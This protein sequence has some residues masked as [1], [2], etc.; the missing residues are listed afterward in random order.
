[1]RI[2]LRLFAT[3]VILGSSLALSACGGGSSGSSGNASTPSVTRSIL[4]ISPT[5]ALTA[6]GAATADIRLNLRDQNGNPVTN[7]SATITLQADFGNLQYTNTNGHVTGTLTSTQSGDDTVSF[8]ID[9]SKSPNTGRVRFVAGPPDASKS[10]ITLRVPGSST[11]GAPQG[12]ADATSPLLGTVTLRDQYGNRILH[13]GDSVMITTSL[14]AVGPVT[15][16]N[17][18]TYTANITSITAGTETASFALG[19][20]TP[21][22]PGSA[23]V[24]YATASASATAS[25]ASP[26]AT[27]ASVYMAPW[28]IHSCS[29]SNCIYSDIYEADTSDPTGS[30]THIASGPLMSANFGVVY[31][32]NYDPST[33]TVKQLGPATLVYAK[34]SSLYTLD[35]TTPGATPERLSTLSLTALCFVRLI[36]P[37]G[38]SFGNSP[39]GEPSLVYVNGFTSPGASTAD[40]TSGSPQSWLVPV[41]GTATTA[42]VSA[43]SLRLENVNAL[44]NPTNGHVQ[45][46]VLVDDSG[47]L[48]LY[49]TD[50]TH[51]TVLQ[52]GVAPAGA[53]V[54][55]LNARGLHDTLIVDINQTSSGVRSDD[56]YRVTKTGA[57]HLTTLS[58]STAITYFDTSHCGNSTTPS[59]YFL[60]SIEDTA[61]NVFFSYPNSSGFEIDKLGA[62]GSTPTSVY[63]ESSGYCLDD[64]GNMPI[65]T[66]GRLMFTES[67]APDSAYPASERTISIDSNGPASQSPVT[68]ASDTAALYLEI[69]YYSRVADNAWITDYHCTDSACSNYTNSVTVA[70]AD[71]T[72]QH[73]FNSASIGGDAQQGSVASTGETLRK[74]IAIT[75]RTGTCTSTG[76]VL[77]DPV[78]LGPVESPDFG[79]GNCSDGVFM[80]GPNDQ[81]LLGNVHDSGNTQAYAFALFG[82]TGTT[83]AFGPY[84]APSGYS[85][86]RVVPMY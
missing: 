42:P 74:Y 56:L 25:F 63:N 27:T 6:D 10:S 46:L 40:C 84:M 48:D 57:T 18:G 23:K 75:P 28:T 15:D 86:P 37:Y 68:L 67:V 34:D 60:Q 16:H 55:V 51:H 33:D 13:G 69:Q 11:T 45:G 80:Y 9:G 85:G 58:F 26:S 41:S 39:A 12:I 7:S 81:F 32:A 4:S 43:S 20:N 1:M 2:Q 35:L 62:S 30:V 17:D 71:G 31:R 64:T 44:V 61:G 38:I 22:M 47:D 59:A 70:H 36:G 3:A 50:L 72:I 65:D 66:S 83:A 82:V 54:Q 77:Y 21:A 14:G 52:A 8:S 73:V 53:H 19:T 79:S 78:T 24:T 5:N 29:S 49:S 76:W